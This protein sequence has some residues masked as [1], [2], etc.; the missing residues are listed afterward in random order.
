MCVCWAACPAHLQPLVPA[1]PALGG[2][3]RGPS[4]P[5]SST[6]HHT[7]MRKSFTLV[8]R[9]HAGPQCMPQQ[10]Q[11]R[12]GWW[13]TCAP[14]PAC[15]CC[16]GGKPPCR[17]V[18]QRLLSRG[19][20]SAGAGRTH[21]DAMPQQLLLTQAAAVADQPRALNACSKQSSL[22]SCWAKMRAVMS[23][24]GFLV[25]PASFAPNCC[26]VGGTPYS[27]GPVALC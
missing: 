13:L 7:I 1:C 3:P 24:R 2:S 22:A 18:K 19:Q 14:A 15:C 4:A 6:A 8:M 23:C 27:P 26:L 25:L 16:L 5:S 9:M 21:W 20:Q 11:A 12:V 10:Q 17:S